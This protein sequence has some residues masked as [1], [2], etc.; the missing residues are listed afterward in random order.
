MEEI[1]LRKTINS[2]RRNVPGYA[3]RLVERRFWELEIHQKLNCISA[4]HFYLPGLPIFKCKAIKLHHKLCS[5]HLTKSYFF[6]FY[7]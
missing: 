7:Q 4:S 2:I 3:K 1:V 6:R 5:S